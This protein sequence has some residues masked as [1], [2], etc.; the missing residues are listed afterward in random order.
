MRIDAHRPCDVLERL[1]A[2]IDECLL[3]AVARLF[4][5]RAG[6]DNPGW[7]RNALQPR[8]DIDAIAHQIA[9]SLLDDV[10]EMNADADFDAS[11]GWQTSVAF[12]ETVL[13]FDRAAYGVDYTAELDKNAVPSPLDDSTMMHGDRRINQIAA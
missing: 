7:L 2:E 8:S 1:L 9:V 11:L 10:S 12:D 4:V 3:Q 6:Q 13:H 5:G